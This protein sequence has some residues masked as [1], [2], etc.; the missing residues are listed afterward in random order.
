M[1]RQASISGYSP[2]G[3]VVG[4]FAT[5]SEH[6]LIVCG[7]DMFIVLLA[8][9]CVA[10][11]KAHSCLVAGPQ[12]SARGPLRNEQMVRDRRVSVDPFPL[13]AAAGHLQR[14]QRA[15]SSCSTWR[16]FYL[17]L[18]AAFL[19]L[20]N[21]HSCLWQACGEGRFLQEQVVGDRQSSVDAFSLGPRAG[22]VAAQPARALI[23]V[24][25]LM[26]VLPLVPA[27][28]ASVNVPRCSVAGQQMS[29]RGSR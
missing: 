17:V 27:C 3:V 1:R 15:N 5:Q 26:C 6:A 20:V 29:L 22:L 12:M 25:V 21:V 13:G 11:V 14:S 10:S 8:P 24:G 7:V 18:L 2:L 23:M 4:P 16:L 9:V 28:S 19:A